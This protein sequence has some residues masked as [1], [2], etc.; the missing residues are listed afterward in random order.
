M[1]F[2]MILAGI[3]ACALGLVKFRWFGSLG[4]ASGVTAIGML[5]FIF[6]NSFTFSTIFATLLIMLHGGVIIG[7]VLYREFKDVIYVRK[8]THDFDDGGRLELWEKC[9]FAAVGGLLCAFQTAPITFRL[10]NNDDGDI[11]VIIGMVFMLIAFIIETL[12]DFQKM[13]AKRR[14]AGRFVS[15]GLYRFVR[16]PNYFGEILFWF[17]VFITGLSTYCSFFQWLA[18]LIGLFGTAY[19]M[20]CRAKRL[21]YRQDKNY[22]SD[23]EYK[24]Y[25]SSTP[26]IIPFAPIYTLE[27]MEWLKG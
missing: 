2:V 18:A 14:N 11:F 15:G 24:T 19:I 1:F 4:M 17:G 5:E 21:E 13:S 27:S 12:A 20:L 8:I 22:G 7:Y 25:S 6:F 10:M 3:A 26:I 16:C 23:E 9:I